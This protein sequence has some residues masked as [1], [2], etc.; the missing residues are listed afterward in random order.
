MSAHQ[1]TCKM[2]FSTYIFPGDCVQTMLGGA[3]TVGF[4][5]STGSVFWPITRLYNFITEAFTQPQ[6]PK[7]IKQDSIV[8][9]QG[10]M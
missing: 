7:L 8:L 10:T 1:Y 3:E 2:L 4:G 9:L 5:S 6:C